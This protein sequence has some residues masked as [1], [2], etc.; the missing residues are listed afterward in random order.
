[1]E[2]SNKMVNAV[3]ERLKGEGSV[4]IVPV[5]KLNGIMLHGLSVRKQA[6]GAA[7][8]L[9]LEELYKLYEAGMSLSSIIQHVFEVVENT[10]TPQYVNLKDYADYSKV[11][12]NLSIKLVNAS[13]N[14]ELLKD[15]PHLRFHDLAVICHALY[16]DKEAGQASVMVRNSHIV[17]WGVGPEEVM[18]TALENAARIAPAD[19]VSITQYMRQML[20]GREDKEC[21]EWFDYMEN[22][23]RNMYVLSNKY[24]KYGAAVIM[25]KGLLEQI[26]EGL[27]RDYVIIPSSVHE[28]LIMPWFDEIGL[29]ELDDMVKEVNNTQLEPGEVLSDHVYMYHRDTKEVEAVIFD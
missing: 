22:D 24:K 6:E 9:Y 20:H 19:M 8:T 29:K 16:Q 14:E 26:G 15:V 12:K 27:Q 23:P 21:E 11:K 2:F 5:S 3:T 1:M 7:P 17:M 28:V 25:Y 13:Y 18:L 10:A 4:D